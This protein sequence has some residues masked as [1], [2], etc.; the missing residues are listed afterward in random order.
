MLSQLKCQI[1]CFWSKFVL[2]TQLS[3]H[4]L[5]F[6]NIWLSLFRIYGKISSCKKLR[7]S[8]VDPAKNVSRTDRQTDRQKDGL[9]NR[10]DFIGPLWQRWRFDHVFQKFENKIFWKLVLAIFYFIK[11]LFF[12]HMIDL[13]KLWKMF[14]ILSKKLILFSKYSNFL[15]FFLFLSTLFRFKKTNR[16]GI[17][18]DV[19]N[20]LA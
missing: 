14:F 5:Q 13:Q 17:I 18:Y 6:F 4:Q 11:C 16:S 10:T 8:R 7:M 1:F 2:F 19:I 3:R 12:H 15:Y 20:W 9:M